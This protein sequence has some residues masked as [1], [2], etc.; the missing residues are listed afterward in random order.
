VY[1]KHIVYFIEFRERKKREEKP[2]F[3]IG[4]KSNCIFDGKKIIGSDGKVYYGSSRAKGYLEALEKDDILVSIL[5]YYDSHEECIS[6]EKQY[7]IS[8]DV[9]VDPRYWN[10]AIAAEN[11]Y[12]KADYGTYRHSQTG[13]VVRLP[14]DHEMVKTGVYVGTTKGKKWYT[15]GI[16]NKIFLEN[17]QPDGWQIGRTGENFTKGLLNYMKNNPM[18]SDIA[19]KRAKV[20]SD[21]MSENPE[22][23]KEG[24]KRQRAAVS[25]KF[26]GVPKSKESNLKRSEKNKGRLMLKNC[27][28]GECVKIYK[29]ELKNYDL[30]LWVNPYKLADKKLGAKWYNNGSI[31]KKI[32]PDEQISDGFELGR[33]KVKTKG[34]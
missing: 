23:Y 34:K 27:I 32:F 6:A 20:R 12:T 26:K 18:D 10:L 5:G 33:I 24:K 8:N 4:S 9:V 22:K 31:E 1:Y 25:K 30:T 14:R 3:Y 16:E 29:D 21:R 11:N 7:H 28:T 17:Q 19:I 2:Y 13:K 15:N